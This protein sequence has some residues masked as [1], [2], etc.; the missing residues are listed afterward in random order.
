VA[1]FPRTTSD[2]REH[3]PPTRCVSAGAAPDPRHRVGVIELDPDGLRDAGVTAVY[4]GETA[5]DPGVRFA[6]H[7]AGGL[8]AA[9]RKPG[10]SGDAGAVGASVPG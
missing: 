9:H 8:K 2:G 1:W 10:C 5:N 3:T 7:L 4:V 6:Q